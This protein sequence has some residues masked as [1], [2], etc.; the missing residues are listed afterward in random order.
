MRLRKGWCAR[1]S[2]A[3]SLK[4]I[5]PGIAQTALFPLTRLRDGGVDPDDPD[6]S[7]EIG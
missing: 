1:L 5:V 7:E 4:V 3:S 6:P 2:I